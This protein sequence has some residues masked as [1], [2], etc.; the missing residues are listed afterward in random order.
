MADVTKI[1]V[2]RDLKAA[3]LPLNTEVEERLFSEDY[4]RKLINLLK[5]R[6]DFLVAVIAFKDDNSM[7][8]FRKMKRQLKYIVRAARHMEELGIK[9]GGSVSPPVFADERDQGDFYIIHDLLT[10]KVAPFVEHWAGIIAS[11]EVGEEPPE[12]R[13]FNDEADPW[14]TE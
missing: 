6:N 2:A 1:D 5:A 3:G 13:L 7:P 9:L 8:K 4:S 14:R 10:Q 12:V 11:L